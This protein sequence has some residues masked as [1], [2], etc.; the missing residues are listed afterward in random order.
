MIQRY[1][2][3]NG[4]GALKLNKQFNDYYF[5]NGIDIENRCIFLIG[6]I[7]EDS[8]RAAIQ[9]MY[10]MDNSPKKGP[11]ELRISSFG[12]CINDM[13]TLHDVT[14][15]I[16]SPVHTT[17]LGKVMSAAVLLVAC[18][19]KGERWCGP[20]TSFMIHSPTWPMDEHKLHEHENVLK[21]TR[22]LWKSWSELMGK[23]TNKDARF[24]SK[25][26]NNN[27]DF[28]FTAEEALEWGIVDNIWDQKS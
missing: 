13:F 22:E 3:K 7:D 5:E 1:A 6:D 23:Y 26:C 8:V 15:T 14:R 2:W 21:N 10:F 25:L 12:G 16:D 27:S 20:N 18:G 28:Y 4:A 19:E 11:I 9:G 24:W 17:G